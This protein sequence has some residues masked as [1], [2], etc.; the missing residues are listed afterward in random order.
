MEKS[1][2]WAVHTVRDLPTYTSGRVVL[3]GDA[4]CPVDSLELWN[5][6]T[7]CRLMR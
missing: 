4:V 7:R 6:L 1:L 2:S 3:I 5:A